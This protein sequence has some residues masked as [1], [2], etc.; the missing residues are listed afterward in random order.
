MSVPDT[1][2]DKDAYGG[3]C[4]VITLQEIRW[5]NLLFWGKIYWE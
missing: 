1:H 3:V 2:E 4:I 5:K